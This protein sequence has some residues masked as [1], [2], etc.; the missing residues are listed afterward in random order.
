MITAIYHAVTAFAHP[1]TLLVLGLVAVIVAFWRRPATPRRPLIA[2]TFL[3]GLL[4]L[5]SSPLLSYVAMLG[6][7]W[8]YPPEVAPTYAGQALVVLS[9]DMRVYDASAKYVEPGYET[10]ARCLHAA[11]VYHRGP[12]RPVLVSGGKDPQEN[13]P[14]LAEMMR[15]FLVKL[16]VNPADVI[17]EQAATTTFENAKFSEKLLRQRGLHRIVLVTDAAHMRRAVAVFEAT[18]LEVIPAP[19]NYYAGRFKLS[20]AAFLPSYGALGNID[21]AAHEWL[22]LAWY[23]L[24]GRL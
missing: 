17:M 22:G 2:A 6:L 10:A 14:S 20:L 19:C 3:V 11:D 5:L 16:G 4:V 24:H 1:F 8:P 9:C 13:G 18:E 12:R 23:R 7:E 15:D 21:Y